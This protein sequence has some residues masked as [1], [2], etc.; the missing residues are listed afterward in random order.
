MPLWI[1]VMRVIVI[2]T[3]IQICEYK[4]KKRDRFIKNSKYYIDAYGL[5]IDAHYLLSCTARFA[6]DG[7]DSN[8]DNCQWKRIGDKLWLVPLS[9]VTISQWDELLVSYDAKY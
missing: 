4:M 2:A 5:Q 9:G 1:S 8:L 7:L 6:N 3:K